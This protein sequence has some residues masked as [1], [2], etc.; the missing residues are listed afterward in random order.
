MASVLNATTGLFADDILLPS[1]PPVKIDMATSTIDPGRP[2][3]WAASEK[4]HLPTNSGVLVT[5]FNDSGGRTTTVDVAFKAKQMA[6]NGQDQ[7]GTAAAI[8]IAP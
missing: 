3:L 8:N 6:R 5:P 2:A 7:L 1:L 4:F